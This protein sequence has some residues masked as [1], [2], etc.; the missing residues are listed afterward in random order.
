[1]NDDLRKMQLGQS[2][3]LLSTIADAMGLISNATIQGKDAAKVSRVLMWLTN[4]ESV[5]KK[6][7]ENLKEGKEP[8][9]GLAPA[10][11]QVVE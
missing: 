3:F 2:E 6:Q 7:I 9:D 1:M 8:M 10:P 4:I 5:C 11:L